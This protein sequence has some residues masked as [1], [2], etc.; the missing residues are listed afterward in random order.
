MPGKL[1]KIL[2]C[3]LA[4]ILECA[5][6]SGV[7]AGMTRVRFIIQ[8]FLLSFLVCVF[9]LG[10]FVP[11]FAAPIIYIDEVG[12][13]YEQWRPLKG[14][15]IRANLAR[16]RDN[17]LAPQSLHFWKGLANQAEHRYEAAIAEF[18]QCGPTDH[19]STFALQQFAQA[20]NGAED[21][22]KAIPLIESLIKRAPNS[23][24][25][26]K[27]RADAYFAKRDLSKAAANYV[28]AAS[29]HSPRGNLNLSKAAECY[30]SLGKYDEAIKVLNVAISHND[31]QFPTIFMTRAACYQEFS[32]WSQ[33]ISDYTDAIKC[34]EMRGTRRAKIGQD[35]VTATA[36]KER[37]KC[38]SK[39]GKFDLAKK[40]REAYEKLTQNVENDFFGK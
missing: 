36:L 35:T 37:A 30:R 33:A 38:Y 18:E 32:K 17:A 40:D 6:I 26:Y 1:G 10:V 24:M 31:W 14:P 13:P 34:A 21:F 19:M 5:G 9:A 11:G 22:D 15:A 3:Y 8:P 29:F 27:L 7:S 4:A 28:K 25:P 16:L 2:S 12:V 23:D 39:L 20:Y